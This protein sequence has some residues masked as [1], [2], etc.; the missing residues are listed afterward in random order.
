MAAPLPDRRRVV[1][2][3]ETFA[4]IV[5]LPVTSAAGPQLLNEQGL[6]ADG[7]RADAMR[8]LCTLQV[9]PDT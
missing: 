7:R 4:P 9:L 1:G 3:A 6:R 8:P 5:E 2:P